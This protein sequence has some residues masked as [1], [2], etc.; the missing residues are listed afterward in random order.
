M[1]KAGL[2]TSVI[3]PWWFRAEHHDLETTLPVSMIEYILS[4]SSFCLRYRKLTWKIQHRPSRQRS[5]YSHRTI[6]Y[7]PHERSEARFHLHTRWP[8]ILS[9]GSIPDE[10]PRMLSASRS[11]PK[12][13][14]CSRSVAGEP[15]QAAR[16]PVRRPPASAEGWL[17]LGHYPGYRDGRTQTSKQAIIL[18]GLNQP[19]SDR[20]M[21]HPRGC[22]NN[23]YFRSQSSTVV[24]MALPF[25]DSIT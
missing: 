12:P 18:I 4:V 9:I 23:K 17:V 1:R 25:S 6:T 10:R 24:W 8:C 2:V 22:N 21:R 5:G 7:Y 20:A 16:S 11:L 19:V 14:G 3:C 13:G 15:D